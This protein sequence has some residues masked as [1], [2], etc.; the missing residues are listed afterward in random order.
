MN[1]QNCMQIVQIKIEELVPAIYNPRQMTEQQALQLEESV[2]RFGL[3]D[4]I[5]VNK[6][7]NRYNIVIGGHQRLKIA[8]KLGFTEVPVFYLDLDEKKERELNLRLNKNLGE[9]DLDALASFDIEALKDAGFSDIDID[10][11]MGIGK[12]DSPELPDMDGEAVKTKSITI[13]AEA[14]KMDEILEEI[15]SFEGKNISEKFIELIKDYRKKK[16]E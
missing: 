14:E 3:V 8:K 16:E 10:G 6:N 5:I 7:E 12:D 4:P 13:Y 15:N 11:F 1:I 2:K 9:W